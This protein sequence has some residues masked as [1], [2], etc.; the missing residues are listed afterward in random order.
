MRRRGRLHH[1]NELAACFRFAGIFLRQRRKITA[2]HFFMKLC[3]F[4][5]DCCSA[6][7]KRCGQIGKRL[8][9]ARPAFK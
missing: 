6:R 9:N 1:D 8:S 2:F 3:Q 7:S 5:A 4:T